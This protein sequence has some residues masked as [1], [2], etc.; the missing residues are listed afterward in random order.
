MKLSFNL[1]IQLVLA[2]IACVLATVAIA[3]GTTTVIMNAQDGAFRDALSPAALAAQVEIAQ[4]LVPADSEALRELLINRQRVYGDASV[5]DGKVLGGIAAA[6]ILLGGILGIILARRLGRP[7][8]EVSAAA[9]RVA[10]GHLG[11]RAEPKGGMAGEARALV[12]NFNAMA[13]ALE[14]YQRRS[15][16][17]Q[18]AIA[19]ELRTPLAILR[20]R[21]EGMR[22]GLFPKDPD[23]IDGLISQ[24]ESLSRIVDDLRVLSLA[25]AG[26][27]RITPKQLDISVTVATLL[28]VIEP[29][30]TAYGHHIERD[31]SFAPVWADAGRLKQATLALLDNAR[32][33][34]SDSAA[35]R[36]E[37]GV[38]GNMAV[39]RV[40][41]RG[42][43]LPAAAS[44]I[45]ETFWRAEESRSR[46]SGG[47][48]LG[49]SVVAA[50]ARAHNGIAS[51][52]MRSGGGAVFSI[53]IPQDP[54]L[55]HGTSALSPP[56]LHTPLK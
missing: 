40:L 14:S 16:E 2:M 28:N 8:K 12:D 21:L 39:I 43:G 55:L 53:L 13:Q 37:T 3:L 32:Q 50:I 42:P 46:E 33:H 26:E 4:G 11:A 49:L 45:F 56:D 6:S 41:D 48:G 10:E 52:E 47:S 18:A 15:I 19:H 23:T 27:L 36:V 17:S 51:A 9:R 20:G 38:D 30:L 22:E 31:L 1:Q 54:S 7:L 5:L 25:E 35:I 24:V 34:A 29:E 44:R